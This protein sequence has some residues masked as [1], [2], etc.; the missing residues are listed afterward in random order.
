MRDIEQSNKRLEEKSRIL[1]MENKRLRTLKDQM[2]SRLERENKNLKKALNEEHANSIKEEV[3]EVELLRAKLERQAKVIDELKHVATDAN[4]DVL[5]VDKNGSMRSLNDEVSLASECGTSIISDDEDGWNEFDKAELEANYQQLSKEYLQLKKA[6]T[7]LQ[8]M[9]GGTLDP[10]REAKMRRDLESDLIESQAT[11]EALQKSL[12]DNGTSVDWLNEKRAMQQ[13]IKK[14]NEKVNELEYSLKQAE[15]EKELLE[16]QLLETSEG[17]DIIETGSPRAST[18]RIMI[19]HHLSTDGAGLQ[20]ACTLDSFDEILFSEL[21]QRLEALNK[22]CFLS[23]PDSELLGQ[24]LKMLNVADKRLIAMEEEIT[25]LRRDI[26]EVENER[27]ILATDK[28]NMTAEL[29]NQTVEGQSAQVKVN[30]LQQTVEQLKHVE[31]KMELVEGAFKRSEERLQ[32]ENEKLKKRLSDANEGR[33]NENEMLQQKINENKQLEQRYPHSSRCLLKQRVTELERELNLRER[34]LNKTERQRLLTMEKEVTQHKKTIKNLQDFLMEHETKGAEMQEEKTLLEEENKELVQ[35]TSHLKMKIAELGAQEAKFQEKLKDCEENKNS[36][37]EI[38]HV[39][40]LQHSNRVTELQHK[41]A[42]IDRKL[43]TVIEENERLICQIKIFEDNEVTVDKYKQLLNEIEEFRTIKNDQRIQIQTLEEKLNQYENKGVESSDEDTSCSLS[44]PIDNAHINHEKGD[45]EKTEKELKEKVDEL[46]TSEIELKEEIKNLKS[47]DETLKKT[48]SQLITE[49]SMLVQEKSKVQSEVEELKEEESMLK[50]VIK[51][52]MTENGKLRNNHEIENVSSR[53][54]EKDA[55]RKEL[56]DIQASECMLK[57]Q[58][59]DLTQKNNELATQ[60]SDMSKQLKE[61]ISVESHLHREITELQSTIKELQESKHL[62][63]NQI[64]GD[65]NMVNT[66][67]VLEDTKQ[68]L[69]NKVKLLQGDK[70]ALEVKM[71]EIEQLVKDAGI[72]D[73]YDLQQSIEFLKNKIDKLQGEQQQLKTEAKESKEN[74]NK[75]QTK[76]SEMQDSEEALLEKIS[77]LNENNERLIEELNETKEQIASLEEIRRNLKEKVEETEEQLEELKITSISLG[78]DNLGGTSKSLQDDLG[79]SF[80]YVGKDNIID[81]LKE[82]LGELQ[83]QVTE[84]KEENE[85]LQNELSSKNIVEEVIEGEKT[86]IDFS[87]PPPLPESPPPL[88][89]SLPPLLQDSP[90]TLLPEVILPLNSQQRDEAAIW[91]ELERMKINSNQKID[92]TMDVNQFHVLPENLRMKEKQSEDLVV[93]VKMLEDKNDKCNQDLHNI[94]KEL[95]DMGEIILE[96]NKDIEELEKAIAQ[97]GRRHS[98]HDLHKH[99]LEKEVEELKISILEMEEN[100]EVL[101]SKVKELEKQCSDLEERNFRLKDKVLSLEL[102]ESDAKDMKIAL[103]DMEE[104]NSLLVQHVSDFKNMEEKLN[105]K[106]KEA[107][108]NANMVNALSHE[109]EGLKQKLE[110]IEKSH[111]SKSKKLE[112]VTKM[113]EE[114]MQ[115][116]QISEDEAVEE[117]EVLKSRIKELET[118]EKV[119]LEQISLLEDNEKQKDSEQDVV[120]SLTLELQRVQEDLGIKISKLQEDIQEKDRALEKSANY[121]QELENKVA[122]FEKHENEYMEKSEQC[123]QLKSEC[124]NLKV[125]VQDL[126]TS[127]HELMEIANLIEKIQEDDKKMKMKIQSLENEIHEKENC[128]QLIKE[129]NAELL[130]Q[131]SNIPEL[132]EKINH[133]SKQLDASE[134]DDQIQ[135]SNSVSESMDI[136]VETIQ[137][138]SVQKTTETVMFTSA[139]EGDRNIY[140]M[141]KMIKELEDE[142]QEMQQRIFELEQ[143]ENAFQETLSHADAIMLERESGFLEQIN[144]LETSQGDLKKLLEAVNNTSEDRASD[145]WH[146]ALDDTNVDEELIKP[147][148]DEEI[149]H[150]QQI[151]LELEETKLQQ[152]LELQNINQNMQD[153]IMNNNQRDKKLESSLKRLSELEEIEAKLLEE[154]EKAENMHK[155]L[156]EANEELLEEVA[157]LRL[158]VEDLEST[159][160]AQPCQIPSDESLSQDAEKLQEELENVIMQLQDLQEKEEKLIEEVQDKENLVKELKKINVQLQDDLEIYC[161]NVKELEES[162]KKLKEMLNQ[163]DKSEDALKINLTELEERISE[164]EATKAFLTERLSE[165]HE[166]EDNL[167]R[168]L[169]SS[170]NNFNESEKSLKESQEMLKKQLYDM[171]EVDNELRIH[172]RVMEDSEADL[173]E[174][175]LKLELVAVNAVQQ[176]EQLESSNETLKTKVLSS[177]EAEKLMRIDFNQMKHEKDIL[178]DKICSAEKVEKML[179]GRIEELESVES[180]IRTQVWKLERGEVKLKDRIQELEE[181]N[182]S[183]ERK[184]NQAIELEQEVLRLQNELQETNMKQDQLR[185]SKDQLQDQL[186]KLHNN[187]NNGTMVSVPEEEYHQMK[188]QVTLLSVDVQEQLQGVGKLPDLLHQLSHHYSCKFINDF[189]LQNTPTTGHKSLKD[190]LES[191]SQDCYPAHLTEASIGNFYIL[192]RLQALEDMFEDLEEPLNATRLHNTPGHSH[193]I[194]DENDQ[195]V[196][197]HC[198]LCARKKMQERKRAAEQWLATVALETHPTNLIQREIVTKESYSSFEEPTP[199]KQASPSTRRKLIDDLVNA[200]PTITV[201]ESVTDQSNDNG[202]VVVE[203]ELNEMRIDDNLEAPPIPVEPP[204]LPSSAPPKHKRGSVSSEMSDN[205]PPLPEWPPPVSSKAFVGT[206]APPLRKMNGH[207]ENDG[208]QRPRSLFAKP[209][210]FDSGTETLS[211][212]TVDQETDHPLVGRA[213]SLPITPKGKRET[214]ELPPK[215]PTPLWLKKMMEWQSQEKDKEINEAQRM[216]TQNTI[217]QSKIDEKD[218]LIQEIRKREEEMKRKLR[219]MEHVSISRQKI[220]AKELE[221][222]EKN[223]EI[224]SLK[225]ENW[226]KE[227]EIATLQSR[228]NEL[229]RSQQSYVN[230]DGILKKMRDELD[231][232]KERLRMKENQLGNIDYD[233]KNLKEQLHLST[234]KLEEKDKELRTKAEELRKLRE[235]LD[236]LEKEV[237]DTQTNNAKATDMQQQLESLQREKIQL[238]EQVAMLPEMEEN[239]EA[240]KEQQRKMDLA[241]REKDAVD[242]KLQLAENMLR[243]KTGQE[244]FLVDENASLQEKVNHLEKLHKYKDN[245]EEHYQDIREKFD[246]MEQQKNEAELAICPLKAKVSY[247]REKCKE[248]D[249]LIKKMSRLL[250]AHV[251]SSLS[252]QLLSEVS[253]IQTSLPSEE[254][255]Q[256]LPHSSQLKKSSKKDYLPKGNSAA[257]FNPLSPLSRKSLSSEGLEKKPGVKWQSSHD[258]G[259]Q[260]SQSLHNGLDELD[261]TK[262][263]SVTDLLQKTAQPQTRFGT[264]NDSVEDLLDSL[265]TLSETIRGRSANHSRDADTETSQER[266]LDWLNT[267]PAGADILSRT[268]SRRLMQPSVHLNSSPERIVQMHQELQESHVSHY[269]VPYQSSVDPVLSSGIT[270]NSPVTKG[271]PQNKVN[272]RSNNH[273]ST[274]TPEQNMQINGHSNGLINSDAYLNNTSNPNLSQHNPLSFNG[275]PGNRANGPVTMR[276][277]VPSSNGVSPRQ[278]MAYLGQLNTRDLSSGLTRV[279]PEPSSRPVLAAQP[280]NLHLNHTNVTR[281]PTMHS[282]IDMPDIS[283]GRGKSTTNGHIRSGNKH[284]IQAEPPEPPTQFSVAKQFGK[285]GIL[286]TWIPP[287]MDRT[288]HSNNSQVVGYKLYV[289]GQQRQFVSDAN[290]KKALVDGV[291]LNKPVTFGIQTMSDTGLHS[292][293]VHTNY[294]ILAVPYSTHSDSAA[295]DSFHELT[296]TEGSSVFSEDQEERLFIAVYEYIPEK[297]SPNDF[298]AYELAFEEGDILTIY[299]QKRQDG[300]YQGKVRGKHGLVPSNFIEEIAMSGRNHSKRKRSNNRSNKSSEQTRTSE[301]RRSHKTLPIPCKKDSSVTKQRNLQ[302]EQNISSYKQW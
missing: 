106:I 156:T 214:P 82:E 253:E 97:S 258:L 87:T 127:E 55:L 2:R 231:L 143:K 216:K 299:G 180:Q 128:L 205:P 114:I 81:E 236:K 184:S 34:H 24:T 207:D 123:A 210:S 22:D 108:T 238:Q 120:Q 105:E 230:E 89:V 243:E 137:Q 275:L 50:K 201:E 248:R 172:V 177:E 266:S 265:Q 287:A 183:M 181:N 23:R 298:P 13:Q 204:P 94:Q 212:T 218:N 113:N 107:E 63:D 16:F 198:A 60:R 122:E 66:I 115:K 104:Q 101:E 280:R 164:L 140:S 93:K 136:V 166:S 45:N 73:A 7:Q 88:P 65:E 255:N 276:N 141:E 193:I 167:K 69:E 182:S 71:Q 272:S 20:Y 194:F 197:I 145:D 176:I 76:L 301:A 179:R 90:Q 237:A 51:D 100:E 129:E 18:P 261:L 14:S 160:Q 8:T 112:D 28:V 281:N 133:L 49:N 293:I 33:T 29:A 251:D 32:Q 98:E 285:H 1:E 40:E 146:D 85:K 168:E 222:E 118:K 295:T 91:E 244:M 173:K 225:S 148:K 4:R 199:L 257:T 6:Y 139:L 99:D 264:R 250:Q 240:L 53:D 42:E 203:E 294:N 130:L 126:E 215:P 38:I 119:L 95:E 217:L 31:E 259:G 48:L 187:L 159:S 256:P 227:R 235:K 161:N 54:S 175:V 44:L 188:A 124:D 121:C 271:T 260:R 252:G 288:C 284:S 43:Q 125:R 286:L 245:I 189:V 62:V 149:R 200:L 39:N 103:K 202:S 163:Q 92:F 208:I 289:N 226:Q 147:S 267:S 75:L 77:I 41:M 154:L 254:Y 219:D 10:Q 220:Q 151:I 5:S 74:E 282:G 152:K 70:D 283:G 144:E 27:D 247:L 64:V 241:L 9:V 153:A 274:V 300:F 79:H 138:P 233:E 142:K 67:Q 36:L 296:T 135:R 165:K 117:M 80:D 132:K 209:L 72:A 78:D 263:I 134:S 196:E 46:E 155:T 19:T 57:E 297:H 249:L 131:C 102:V 3:S 292:R 35:E 116:L 61:F 15:D 150:L 206:E 83:T 86:L 290:L 223:F 109:T 262:G 277:A 111:L 84:L 195:P 171:E 52:Q 170:E 56:G 185:R 26:S 190:A 158:R 17:D 278:D 279:L 25:S 11:I 229:Q 270:S 224:S 228:I 246:T 191:V 302:P 221:L 30:E 268:R 242:R 213:L 174:K 59:C 162:E 12:Q 211:T 157:L 96:K 269:D 68:Q 232:T 58:V 192:Y 169:L 47:S 21:K 178:N 110:S 273:L 37:E 291:D 239:I 186:N 234:Q